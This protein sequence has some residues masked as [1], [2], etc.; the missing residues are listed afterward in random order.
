MCNIWA[1]LKSFQWRQLDELTNTSE[2]WAGLTV[3]VDCWIS[4]NLQC[5]QEWKVSNRKWVHDVFNAKE[6]ARFN[7]AKL[8][9]IFPREI[10]NR[11]ISSRQRR[12]MLFWLWYGFNASWFTPWWWCDEWMI[13]QLPI[14]F[15]KNWDWLA[16]VPSYYRWCNNFWALVTFFAAQLVWGPGCV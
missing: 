8:S 4:L 13:D 3:G 12:R 5:L 14:F 10:W 1:Q 6:V 16:V 2:W 11:L 7:F 9:G 15:L